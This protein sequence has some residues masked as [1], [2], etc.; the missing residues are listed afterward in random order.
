MREVVLDASVVLKWFADEQRG[1]SEARQ[2]RDEYLAGRLSVV[3]PSLL[4]PE[5]LNVVGRRWRW[6]DHAVL[7]LADALGALSFG[8][9]EPEL[10]SVAS[11]V[12]RGLTA[13][14]AAYVALAEARQLVLVTDDDEIA[15]RAPGVGRPLVEGAAP[16]G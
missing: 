6:G 16:A 7:E 13:Y 11:W 4:F 9:G 2:L 5:I 14:D 12:S 15:R 10:Q 1:S 8:V 3:V